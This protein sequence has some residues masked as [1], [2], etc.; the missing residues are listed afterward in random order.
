LDAGN[1]SR[2]ILVATAPLVGVFLQRP[3]LAADFRLGGRRRG[4]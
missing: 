2:A 1:D 4:R 3:S